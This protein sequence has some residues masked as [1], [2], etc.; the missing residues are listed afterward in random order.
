MDVLRGHGTSRRARSSGRIKNEVSVKRLGLLTATDKLSV[1]VQAFKTFIHAS[2]LFAENRAAVGELEC[3]ERINFP[4][5]CV[6]ILASLTRVRVR[7][8]YPCLSQHFSSFI[9]FFHET[10][11]SSI[12]IH[13]RVSSVGHGYS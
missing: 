6:F 9:S 7:H 10:G 2:V 8:A 1:V 11:L 13:V 12:Y 3:T 4:I 5:G